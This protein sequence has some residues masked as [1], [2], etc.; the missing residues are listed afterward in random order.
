ME[1]RNTHYQDGGG[2]ATDPVPAGLGGVAALPLTGAAGGHPGAPWGPGRGG[3]GW[4]PPGGGGAPPDGVID[5]V[6]VTVYL[7]RADPPRGRHAQLPGPALARPPAG[8]TPSPESF[9]GEGDEWG[10]LAG[11]DCDSDIFLRH[12]ATSDDDDALYPG[13]TAELGQLLG[14]LGFGRGAA[15]AG[16]GGREG[17]GGRPRALSVAYDPMEAAGRAS[18]GRSGGSEPGPGGPVAG[19]PRERRCGL[20]GSAARDDWVS[21]EVAWGAMRQ[22]WGGGGGDGDGPA[23]AGETVFLPLPER[24]G[25]GVEQSAPGFCVRGRPPRASGEAST[26]DG[27]GLRRGAGGSGPIDTSGLQHPAGGSGPID[28]RRGPDSEGSTWHGPGEGGGGGE[29]PPAGARDG[30]PPDKRKRSGTWGAAAARDAPQRGGSE[31]CEPP[32]WREVRSGG[33]GEVGGTPSRRKRMRGTVEESPGDPPL[34][35]P[36]PAS[37]P[38]R[39]APA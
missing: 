39:R 35:L 8:R 36:A 22:A 24:R 37:P 30:R 14:D 17:G 25:V 7:E 13:T 20:D 3:A 12:G 32:S 5:A 27:S 18:L 29:T 23:G 6:D 15:G 4:G 16:A 21:R 19:A 26:L 11:R 38:K 33:G 31:Q 10:D 34:P 9:D 2:V 1:D 28:V